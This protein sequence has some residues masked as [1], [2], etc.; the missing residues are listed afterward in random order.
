MCRNRFRDDTD[1][2]R[3]GETMPRGS[4]VKQGWQLF[5]AIKPRR[6]KMIASKRK[7]SRHQPA[8]FEFFAGGFIKRPVG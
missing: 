3:P 1:S 6:N 8:G 2:K 5:E 7:N 4:A